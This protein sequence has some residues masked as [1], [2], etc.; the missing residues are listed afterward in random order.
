VLT[1]TV[2]TGL[3]FTFQGLGFN[4]PQR[5][6]NGEVRGGSVVRFVLI[7]STSRLYTVP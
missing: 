3:D 5:L 2:V 4:K 7:N 1:K 6:I